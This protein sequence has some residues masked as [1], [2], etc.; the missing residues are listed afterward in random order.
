MND[1]SPGRTSVLTMDM[2]ASAPLL[3]RLLLGGGQADVRLPP[4]AGLGRLKPPPR[5]R[6]GSRAHSLQAEE[7]ARR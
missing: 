4:L 3:V 7:I 2:D 6:K 1:D 5:T